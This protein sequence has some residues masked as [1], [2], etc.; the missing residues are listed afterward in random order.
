MKTSQ[1]YNPVLPVGA[2]ELVVEAEKGELDE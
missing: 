2:A 1:L